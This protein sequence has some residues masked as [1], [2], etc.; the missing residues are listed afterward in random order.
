MDE[1]LCKGCNTLKGVSEFNK[2]SNKTK[3]GEKVVK[4]HYYCIRC[5]K[6]RHRVEPILAS[7]QG[8]PGRREWIAAIPLSVRKPMI[9]K[10]FQE[11]LSAELNLPETIVQVT[12]VV[13]IDP[14]RETLRAKTE[15]YRKERD[16]IMEPVEKELSG[17]KKP[18]EGY[19]YVISH[20]EI[21]GLKI[22]ETSDPESRLAQY[23]MY[24]SNPAFRFEGLF[25]FGDRQVAEKEI[26]R[27]LR[28]KN[29]SGE[30]FDLTVEEA[31]S[32]IGDYRKKMLE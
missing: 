27:L 1:K 3:S 24:H 4:P 17:L 28:E 10:K 14:D 26:H 2:C 23:Q 29:I 20:P 25:F 22:G 30:W 19:V 31:I 6:L 18:T 7:E 8:F 32:F 5:H 9:K 16:K 15:A 13:T 21:R 11:L 12:S